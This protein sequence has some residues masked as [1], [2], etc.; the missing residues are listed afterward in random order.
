M[1]DI[2]TNNKIRFTTLINKDLL[3][4]I[5]LISYFTNSKLNETINSSL[6]LYIKDFETSNNTSLNSIIDLQN[7]F[8]SLNNP[9]ESTKPIVLDDDKTI[10]K[11]P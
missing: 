9:K 8:T 3:S 2:T 11:K 6:K 7:N 5:K 1:K 10:S 4:Q